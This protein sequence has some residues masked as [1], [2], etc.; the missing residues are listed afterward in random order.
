MQTR[1]LGKSAI[2]VSDIC[3]GT[4]TFGSQTDE[5]AAHRIL[6][7]C[8]DAGISFY[9]TAEGYP[10]PPDTKWVGR[11]EEI[12]GRWM[13]TKPRDA[14]I[15]ATKVSGPSH[16]W[17]RSPKRSGMTALD[18]RNIM[19]AVEDSLVKLQTDYIDLY[20]THWPDHDTPYDETMEVL[21]ELVRAGKVRITGCSNET[22]WGL[23]KSIAAAERLGTV[24]YHTI[25]NNFSLNNRRFE[26]ELAQVCRQEGV[27]LIPYSPIAGGVLS[28]KYQD[29]A[30]PEGARF[31]RYLAM[32][33]RQAAMGRRFVNEQ[34]LA[35]TQRF[36]ALAADAGMSPV[37]MAVA[38]SKQHDFVASTIVGVSR[39][40][41]LDEILAAIDLVLP[42]DLMKAI[43]KVSREIRYPMG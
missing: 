33:G 15:M 7:R 36:M 39:E 26:D 16:V 5:A 17:F 43:D 18:R 38:W 42:A 11:T 3:M 21:D 13:K 1:R 40:D 8:F 19:T 30:T 12:V 9:D 25:Q 14:I 24:R 2:V 22:A 23:M 35:S 6:D 10:V 34:S 4:M 31:S 20:Q 32:E 37:T 41:Q 28:G 29:G 27:S